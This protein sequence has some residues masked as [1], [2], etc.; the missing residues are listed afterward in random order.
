MPFPALRPARLAAL[1]ATLGSLL[2]PA[3]CNDNPGT[4]IQPPL[5][6]DLAAL[7]DPLIG[8]LGSGNVFL[9][10]HLPHGMVKL[11]P[12]SEDEPLSIEGYE[13]GLE[14]IEG[15][16]HTHLEGP[17]GSGYGYGQV[18]LMPQRGEVPPDGPAPASRFSHALESATVGTY[19]VTLDDVDT[20]VELAAT[21]HCGVHRYTYRGAGQARL[22]LD[23]GHSRGR[24]LDGQ[25]EVAGE[26][27]LEGF[28]LWSA[29]PIIGKLM[30]KLDQAA[31]TTTGQMRLFYAVEFDRPFTSFGVGT[32]G[33]VE[34]GAT[35]AQGAEALAWVGFG[36]P[37]GTP[38][39]VEA[40]VCLSA[41][42][43]ATARESLALEVRDAT[44][45]SVRDA[46]HAQW[47]LYM[48]RVQVEGGTAEQRQAFYTAL[49]HVAAAPVN[50]DERGRFWSGADGVGAVFD[51][52]GA[53]FYL[54][55]WCLWDT[56]RT[57]HPLQ[58]LLEPER[59]N[60]VLESM[61]HLYRQGGWL[62]I[63]SWRATGY[64][65]IMI[66][67]PFTPVMVDAWRK[68]FTGFDVAK[69]YEGMVKAA[70]EWGPNPLANT[71]CGYLELGT[72]PEYVEQGWVGHECDVTEAASMTL[73]YAQDDWCL[74]QLAAALGKADDAARYLARSGSWKHHWN[75]DTGFLQGRRRDGSWL[76][77]FAPDMEEPNSFCESRPWNYLWSVPHDVPGLMD[78][79]GGPEAMVAKLDE[80]FQGGHHDPSNEPDFHAPYLYN[81]AGA[82]ARTQARVR[83][84][85]ASAYGVGPGG[86]V[87][88]DDAGAM[89][90]W[91]VF[92]AL[93][94]YPVNPGEPVYALGSPLFTRAVLRLDG[95]GLK[96]FTLEAPGSSEENLYIQSAELNGQPLDKP[97][98][99]HSALAAG[100]TLTLHMGST[101]SEWGTLQ[102]ENNTAR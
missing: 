28:G 99:E 93:G 74:A 15:F 88:N 62:D 91:L 66:G 12:D 79:L 53:G 73:E 19:R 16:S 61:V 76:T 23:V 33:A 58:L 87:G 50:V 98:L 18:L 77:P 35:G 92:S 7:V 34:A 2:A 82:P 9:G 78:K 6:Q 32:A 47:N 67:N 11:G 81:W 29:Q 41:I 75:P 89:S 39:T 1:L 5:D 4:R 70:D 80:Y 86:L 42:D 45:E 63:C 83:A 48:N 22:V 100:G 65:R 85:M 27:G 55:D 44:M 51:T 38:L 59:R 20:D 3:A 37:Q 40:R 52:P 68:G 94:F 21:A 101:P 31:G 49:Y 26:R 69:A 95:T 10:V 71:A 60:D 14:R 17:G 90:A 97:F 64:S 57:T 30:E 46:A 36:E 8:T 102:A 84:L 24:S 56:F 96:T 25:V 13:Y 54:D 72:P 43:L